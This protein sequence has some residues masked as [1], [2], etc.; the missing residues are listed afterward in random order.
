[1][2]QSS[3]NLNLSRLDLISIPIICIIKS[4]K[5][6]R[7]K[8]SIGKNKIKWSKEFVP[9]NAPATGSLN[10]NQ[11]INPVKMESSRVIKNLNNT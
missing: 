5:R 3:L 9:I 8:E 11:E 7:E 4:R 1:M 2:T 10:L 6:E